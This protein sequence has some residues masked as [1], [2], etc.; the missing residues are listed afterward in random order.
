MTDLGLNS[1][2]TK[3]NNS[4]HRVCS[5]YCTLSEKSSMRVH[6][7]VH[8]FGA[9]NKMHYFCRLKNASIISAKHDNMTTLSIRDF[10]SNLSASLDRV[11]QGETVLLR[12][13]NKTYTIVVVEDSDLSIS[14]QLAAKIE[15]ARQEHADG[16]AK[17]FDN[18]AEAQKWMDE[19]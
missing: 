5:C 3:N 7:F 18:A 10:R 15:K 19:L 12:R 8:I 11:D 9:F 4:N 1:H 2:N 16:S 14:P 17:G 13:R 6:I